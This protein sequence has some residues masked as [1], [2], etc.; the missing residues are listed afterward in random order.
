MA[1]AAHSWASGQT[2]HSN[3]VRMGNRDLK[4]SRDEKR[5]RERERE[6]GQ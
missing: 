6:R 3:R 1:H 2:S 4:Q 5:E